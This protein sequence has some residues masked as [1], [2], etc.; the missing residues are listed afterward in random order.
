M[1]STIFRNEDGDVSLLEDKLISIIGFGNQAR[2]IALNLRDSG[3]KIIIAPHTEEYLSRAQKDNFQIEEIPKA[4][5]LADFIFI[6][7]D[8]DFIINNFENSIKPSLEEGK[9]LI[10]ANGYS[11]AYNKLQLPTTIDVLLL[12]PKVPGIGIREN[13][14]TNKGFFSF[15]SVYQDSSQ[16]ALKTLLAL[17]KA[18]GGLKRG[19]IEVTSEQQTIMKLFSTQTF[20]YALIQIMM[21][22]ILRLVDEG[23]PPEAIFVELILSGEGGF[24]VDK[25][26]EVGMIKQMNFHSQTSQYGQMSRGMKFRQV[27]KKVEIIQRS[28]LQEIKDGT[29]VN[30]WEK[31]DSKI[32]L[33]IMRNSIGQS[34]FSKVEREVRKKL[35]FEHIDLLTDSKIPSESEIAALKLAE[36]QQQVKEFYGGI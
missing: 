29:F 15:V 35:N 28:I 17:T 30:E 8:D 34:R 24:T 11:V 19:A 25:M 6:L 1:Q 26:I 9:T 21:R 20:T 23:Y 18:I 3:L 22:S 16:N 7:T 36:F 14:L 13:F 33:N 5:K 27:T 31:E 32:K 4:I 10:F 12:S 2:A